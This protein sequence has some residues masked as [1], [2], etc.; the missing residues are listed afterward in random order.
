MDASIPSVVDLT[1]KKF[2]STVNPSATLNAAFNVLASTINSKMG[3]NSKGNKSSHPNARNPTTGVTAGNVTKPLSSNLSTNL[4]SNLSSNLW[5]SSPSK[6]H[7][8]PQTTH[9]TTSISKMG[10]M[11]T[12][13]NTNPNPNLSN[14][15]N[16]SNHSSTIPTTVTTPT[17]FQVSQNSNLNL[18]AS[19]PP[20]KPCPFTC[21]IVDTVSFNYDANRLQN[22]DYHHRFQQ[23]LNDCIT[24]QMASDRET[25]LSD[26]PMKVT[27]ID[28]FKV[29][30]APRSKFESQIVEENGSAS[31]YSK[32]TI[33]HHAAS[34]N[35]SND[36]N[37]KRQS[38]VYKLF[39][40]AFD[41][42]IMDRK[43]F[44]YLSRKV[45]SYCTKITS[46]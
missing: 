9:P 40:P 45:S 23:H 27:G 39:H 14:L 16:L 28:P 18:N 8:F 34:S 30:N 46:A 35:H 43:L 21:G 3:T 22:G 25:N 2:A 24:A 10:P 37:N 42:G 20:S 7:S 29:L 5:P 12:N 4:S 26:N 17:H 38:I 11:A 41:H 13:S 32:Y 1:A 31:D 19:A 36:S 33:F 15:S 6:P 44:N